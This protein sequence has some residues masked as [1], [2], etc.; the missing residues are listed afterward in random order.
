M[1]STHHGITRAGRLGLARSLPH[2]FSAK[3]ETLEVIQRK[4]DCSPSGFT[5]LRKLRDDVEFLKTKLVLRVAAIGLPFLV[6]CAAV[7]VAAVIVDRFAL[8]FPSIQKI[9]NKDTVGCVVFSD[10]AAPVL[11][12]VKELDDKAAPRLLTGLH[13]C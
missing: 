11:R 10:R 4:C 1:I 2:V 3:R 12:T 6:S 13:L 7:D 9:D 5:L 8:G